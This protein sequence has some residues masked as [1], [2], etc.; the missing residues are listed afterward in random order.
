M[1]PT[2]SQHVFVVGC[3]RSGTTLLQ[4]LLSAHPQITSF[5]ESKF[6]D[7][8]FPSGATRFHCLG[9]ASRR[10]RIRL[11]D[12]QRDNGFPP[13]RPPLPTLT[14]SALTAHFSAVL[15]RMA[16]QREAD[17]WVEKTPTN[18]YH[19]PFIERE[20]R[21]PKFIH[22]I[23]RGP[24]AIAS[25]CDVR[26]RYSKDWVD[27][28]VSLDLSINRW[29]RDVP[30]SLSYADRANHL[31]IRYEALA[32]ETEQTLELV[33]H[34]LGLPFASTML[35]DYPAQLRLLRLP[36]EHWKAGV[37]LPIENANGTKFYHLFSQPEQKHILRRT[38]AL[39]LLSQT[40]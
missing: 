26:Q 3:A 22:I 19:I 37:M 31:L 25:L 35:S 20:I 38:Q 34:F 12:F 5:T 1:Q 40:L 11:H 2:Y 9:L 10:A 18:L 27:Q 15:D 30:I 24:D 21:Q 8:L 14:P 13:Q 7:S 6:F 39:T 4:S 17:A 33:C 36:K 16:G 29:C 32:D 28:R 23:R